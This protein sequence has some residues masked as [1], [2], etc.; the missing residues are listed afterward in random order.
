MDIGVNHEFRQPY[1]GTLSPLD[2][3]QYRE[4]G[5]TWAK[6]PL[7]V[8]TNDELAHVEWW[9][10]DTRQACEQAL[11]CGMEPIIDLRT[12]VTTL[13][14]L[15]QAEQ[16]ALADQGVLTDDHNENMRLANEAANRVL[17][18]KIAEAIEL[19]RDLCSNWEFWG[20]WCCPWTSRGTFDDLL[21][22]PG[23]LTSV[24]GVIREVQPEA[25]VWLGGYGMDLDPVHIRLT[26]EHG[27][28]KSFDVANWHPYFMTIRDLDV[29][30]ERMERAFTE[31]RE[32]LTQY[33]TH[34]PFASTEWG[35]PT[36]GL[37]ASEE[38]VRYLRSNVVAKGIEQLTCDE[39]VQ[40][41]EQDLS[42]MEA[43]GFETVCVHTLRDHLTPSRHWGGFCGLMTE[44]WRKKPTWDVVQRWAWKGRER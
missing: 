13:D 16:F 2:L 21:T 15:G 4:L 40:W 36:H 33:G 22:Y 44:D 5:L 42:I 41:Y 32:I 20:E 31:A 12:S 1:E 26:C 7:D 10:G 25:R 34:Q 43:H 17:L 28:S 23:M 29:A 19:H 14:A 11:S 39:A 8:S 27:A 3:E 18:D 30:R 9:R 38:T 6:W 37:D 35:Y 24:A